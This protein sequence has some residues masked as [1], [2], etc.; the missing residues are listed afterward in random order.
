MNKNLYDFRI[1]YKKYTLELNNVP[2]EPIKLFDKWF[3]Q[4]LKSN[5]LEPNAMVLSTS[6]N[7]KPSSRVVLL[8]KYDEKGFIF[9][10]NYDSR[11]GKEI[12]KNNNA[13]LLFYWMEFERQVRI[14]GKVVKISSKESDEYFKLRPLDSRYAA[15]ASK[16][17]KILEDR[18][19]LEKEIQKLKK[20]YYDNPPR[21]FNWGG[22]RLIPKYFEFWQ[23]RENRLHDRIVYKK[24]R[25]DWKIFRLYP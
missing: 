18:I 11:K 5:L 12:K 8:K 21:P 7:D 25:K 17:S 15:I 20:I 23:G 14:E 22:Y 4:L 24:I 10:T 1:N 2:E 9:F 13:C 3:H 16:Q 19:L 6:I